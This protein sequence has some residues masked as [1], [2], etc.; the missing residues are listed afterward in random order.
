[1]NEESSKSDDEHVIERRKRMSSIL[2]RYGTQNVEKLRKRILH[3][4]EFL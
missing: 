1:L 4:Y 2:N 3:Y